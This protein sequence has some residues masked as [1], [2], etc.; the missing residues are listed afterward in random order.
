MFSMIYCIAFKAKGLYSI[1]CNVSNTLLVK[2]YKGYVESVEINSPTIHV[3]NSKGDL[4]VEYLL[5]DV[6]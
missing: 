5:C 4:F 2:N 1:A 6:Q 3:H